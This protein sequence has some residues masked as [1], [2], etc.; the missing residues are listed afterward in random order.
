MN[1]TAAVA[2]Q[3]AGLHSDIIN[4]HPGVA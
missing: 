4:R 3:A 1:A 2:G